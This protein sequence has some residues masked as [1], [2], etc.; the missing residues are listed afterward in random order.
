M[1]ERKADLASLESFGTTVAPK[2]PEKGKGKFTHIYFVAFNYKKHA[3]TAD[4][5]ADPPAE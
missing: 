1:E 4:A 2:Y 3:C 5:Q